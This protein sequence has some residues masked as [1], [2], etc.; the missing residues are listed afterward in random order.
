MKTWRLFFTLL[1]LGSFTTTPIWADGY[2]QG[3]KKAA[4]RN[5]PKK[6]VPQQAKAV[7]LANA[8]TDRVAAAFKT[9]I[10]WKGQHSNQTLIKAFKPCAAS[11]IKDAC[12]RLDL[13]SCDVLVSQISNGDIFE[14]HRMAKQDYGCDEQRVRLYQ[15]PRRR[16]KNEPSNDS[17]W[18]EPQPR[19]TS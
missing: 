16:A 7:P 17:H 12:Q 18:D 3:S 19:P 11:Y 8:K 4:Q 6:T 5:T 10:A 15:S 13:K 9:A 2:N 14:L 1:A